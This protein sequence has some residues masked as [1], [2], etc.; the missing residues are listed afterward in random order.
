MSKIYLNWVNLRTFRFVVFALSVP[1]LFTPNG[2]TDN[3]TVDTHEL[4]VEDGLK[5]TVVAKEPLVIDPVA[6]SFD[7]NGYLYV[8]EDR[9]Y[10]DPAEGGK[11]DNKVGRIV[12]LEDNDG[13]G[14]YDKRS[15]FAT[16]FTYPN[17]ILPWKG[18]VFVTCAPDIFYLKDTDDDGI[19]DIREI[20]LT[21]FADTKT[22]QLRMSHPTLGLDGWVYVTSGLNGGE[23]V[24][25]KYPDRPAVS[26]DASDGRFDPETFEFQKVGGKSQFGLTF[27]AYGNRFGC[28]NRHPVLQVVL[29]PRY[30]DRNPYLSFSETIENV[31]KVAAE[32]VVF[33]LKNV[34][35]TS[36]FMPNLM[37]RSHQGT[38]TSASGTFVFNG[39]GL[40]P[41]HKGNVF[42]CESAQNLV[43]RQIFRPDGATF[44]SELAYEGKE[45]LASENEWF[46]PVYMEHGPDDGLYLADM[47]R[48]VIDHPSYVP[49]EIRDKLDFQSGKDMGRIYKVSDKDADPYSSKAN[50]LGSDAETPV[51]VSA[52]ESPQEWQRQTAF[53][54]LLERKEISAEKVL[55][56]CAVQGE[57]PESR[58]YALSLL[59]KFGLLDS[60]TLKKILSD[61]HAGVRGKAVLLASGKAAKDPELYQSVLDLSK[62][63]DPQVRF[64]C[65]L[66]L[67]YLQ[68][69]GVLEAM[70]Y[71]AG[72]DGEDQWARA[73]VLSGVGDRMVPF[74]E[75]FN[76]Q[77]QQNTEAY[78]S[79][80]KDLGKLFGNGASLDECRALAQM[81][82]E[83]DR[84]NKSGYAALL[85]LSEGLS[86]KK[87]TSS[88][89]VLEQLLASKSRNVREE[90]LNS[91][92]RVAESIDGDP[93]QRLQAIQ[94]LGFTHN[95]RSLTVLKKALDPK[96][97][98]LVQ[99][100]AIQAIS[101][102]G[103][104]SSGQLLTA[105]EIWAAFTPT[106]RSSA[107]AVLNSRSVY[108]GILLDAVSDGVITASDVPAVNRK[109]LM[110]NKDPEIRDRSEK[111]FADLEGGDRMKIYEDYKNNFSGKGEL[112]E[113]KVVFERICA[114]C[115]SY[116][117][118]GQDVGPD[119]TGINNQ[120]T[121][122]ILL[123]T[124]VPNYEVYP[125]YQTISVQTAN[126]RTVRGRLLSETENSITLRTASGSDETLLRSGIA[127]LTN[128]GQ[129][130][131][132]DGLEQ[133]MS[134]EE[135]E[136]L[137]TYLKTG[138]SF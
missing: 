51:L 92:F 83:G 29:E 66:V 43:Q 67:G 134:P 131:M 129:S 125:T 58:I 80:I 10:P 45:F 81:S 52:L 135:M 14:R 7:E 128:T 127:S 79:V 88:D 36:D 16:S 69:P 34:S 47:H 100:A 46:R 1:I 24:S 94:L 2:C 61:K 102:Q 119:L 22:S 107:L 31:S 38:Y 87:E 112:A 77:E 28:T 41:A 106:L 3:E 85:G 76:G 9:G 26:F 115:H 104:K 86:G 4:Q 124:L 73:A 137:I 75:V 56:N 33:P 95:K 101:K 54:L 71:L 19:A 11:P 121:D 12:L 57:F 116:N 48:K 114:A 64:K 72:N 62:D 70:A 136:S 130:L 53:R 117:G 37:G 18:G 111:L 97:P 23:V 133:A 99:E 84:T 13:D 20:V 98:P 40:S 110:E 123:H 138:S 32:A 74:L 122:A 78:A 30:L 6:F 68:G 118:K 44:K 35:T 63:P 93:E 96:N 8:V 17:G 55:K 120:P 25:P 82:M 60:K 15:E 126:G 132:P 5:V 39:S 90:T 21:G 42:I 103:K 50:W 49:E 27:D 109:R 91:I 89:S 59:E 108:L 113:G 105:S 65:A